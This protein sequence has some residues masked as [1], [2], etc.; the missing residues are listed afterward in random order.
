MTIEAQN[1]VGGILRSYEK[2][3]R[4]SC[5]VQGGGLLRTYGKCRKAAFTIGCLE[6]VSGVL[7]RVLLLDPARSGRAFVVQ[8]IRPA[9]TPTNRDGSSMGTAMDALLVGV[10]HI[11]GVHAQY[12]R[13]WMSHRSARPTTFHS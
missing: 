13:A 7:L 10:F 12:F 8:Q 1:S 3:P 5:K 2:T 11:R 4:N 9:A 6:A